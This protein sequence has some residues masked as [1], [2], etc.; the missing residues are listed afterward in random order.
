MNRDTRNVAVAQQNKA[1]RNQKR[2]RTCETRRLGAP[3][4]RYVCGAWSTKSRHDFP[5]LL[6]EM[7]P[8]SW[9]LT[10]PLYYL[11][12]PWK[13]MKDLT[14]WRLLLAALAAA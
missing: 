12:I 8:C 2:Q 4:K 10:L 14:F 6:K 11:V 5:H 1:E 13:T 9:A 7:D 3:E